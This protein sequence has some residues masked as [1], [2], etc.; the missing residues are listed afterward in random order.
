MSGEDDCEIGAMCWDADPETLEGTC[1]SFCQG[2]PQAPTCA[3]GSHCAVLNDGGL[4]VC[5]PDC[6]PLAQDCP[7]GDECIPL[8]D[9]ETFVCVLDASGAEGQAFDPCEFA[10]A[11]DPGLLCLPSEMASECDPMVAGCCLPFCDVSA[12]NSCPGVGQ[13]CLAYFDPMQAPAGF[14]DVGVCGLP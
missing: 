3:A 4:N 1:V 13:D 12:A 6:D 10:N 2:S 7:A 8:P 14:E 9:T 5:L 11:C